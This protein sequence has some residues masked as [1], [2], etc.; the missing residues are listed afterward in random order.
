MFYSLAF[1]RYEDEPDRF[2]IPL[3][4]KSGPVDGEFN[5]MAA[6]PLVGNGGP[7]VDRPNSPH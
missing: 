5:P 2:S 4:D 3:C 7:L 6:D 1:S